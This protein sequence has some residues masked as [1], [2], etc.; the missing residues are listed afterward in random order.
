MALFIVKFFVDSFNHFSFQSCRDITDNL[1]DATYDGEYL[2]LF[3]LF[4]G[5]WQNR[6]CF[7]GTAESQ[8]LIV[9]LNKL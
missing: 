9:S 1:A 4:I 8:E 6:Q 7:P 2:L 5:H 3:V